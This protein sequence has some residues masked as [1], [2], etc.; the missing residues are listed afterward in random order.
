MSAPQSPGIRGWGRH[1]RQFT[2]WRRERSWLGR[3]TLLA[4]LAG[5]ALPII[6]AALAGAF[7]ATPPQAARAP[8]EGDV[9]AEAPEIWDAAYEET[10]PLAYDAALTELVVER[11]RGRASDWAQGVRNGWADG[12][13]QAI[14]AMR[15]A[16]E[17]AD[18]P[19]SYVEW[20]VL[21]DMPPRP[22]DQ[23]PD[24]N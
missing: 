16:A 14:A 12:W 17:D 6:I 24:L 21:D 22:A 2:D 1:G 7:D 19:P 15:R 13:N 10:F 20:R 5:L 9:Y 23:P 8:A 3:H 18:L 4:A 11:G